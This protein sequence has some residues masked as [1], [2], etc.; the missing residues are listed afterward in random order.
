VIDADRPDLVALAI[1]FSVTDA[2]L[3]AAQAHRDLIAST[4]RQLARIAAAGPVTDALA[5]SV[6]ATVKR[7]DQASGGPVLID[8][9]AAEPNLRVVRALQAGQ[10]AYETTRDR[11][12]EIIEAWEPPLLALAAA[13]AFEMEAE[14]SLLKRFTLAATIA[15]V[16]PE[17]E[18]QIAVTRAFARFLIGEP[19]DGSIASLTARSERLAGA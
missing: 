6:E 14:T 18:D 15:G 9:T 16:D 4:T 12:L 11:M 10:R 5:D 3:V 1:I 7:F 17:G 19:I 8:V 2:E 13:L